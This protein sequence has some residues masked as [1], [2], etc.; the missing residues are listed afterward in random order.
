MRRE[1]K[2]EAENRRLRSYYLSPCAHNVSLVLCLFTLSHILLFFS[3][4]RFSIFI[5]SP[6]QHIGEHCVYN[7]IR[8]IHSIKRR[9]AGLDAP[10]VHSLR[11]ATADNRIS[12]FFFFIS[13][14]V[15][16]SL[17]T[18]GKCYGAWKITVRKGH[19]IK[20]HEQNNSRGQLFVYDE[21][22]KGITPR[23]PFS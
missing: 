18:S 19:C 5:S 1:E 13:P 9:D 21:V 20:I 15:W 6:K 22:W 10:R 12:T 17:E 3:V 16:L 8:I 7:E 14:S 2:H 23:P 4:S 11:A